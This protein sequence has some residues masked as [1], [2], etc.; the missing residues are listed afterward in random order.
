MASK[1]KKRKNRRPQI[2][3]FKSLYEHLQWAIEVEHFTIPPYLCALWSIKEGTN[4]EAIE[5]IQSVVMEEM[6]HMTLVAN[7]MNAVGIHPEI[8][9]PGFIP[10]YPCR[11]PHSGDHFKVSLERFSKKAIHTFMDIE[12]PKKSG[13]P[14]RAHHYHT[15]AQLYDAVAEGL[16]YLVCEHGEKKVFKGKSHCQVT[17]QHYY[18][19]GGFVFTIDS[20]E[21]AQFAVR[22]I[23]EQGEGKV[24]DKIGTGS[25]FDGD[26]HFGQPPE[27]AH[28]FRFNEIL[29]GQKYVREDTPISGPSGA[30]FDVQWREVHQM[31]KN[32]KVK[33]AKSIPIRNKMNAFNEKYTEL[34]RRLE[35]AFSGEPH[36]IQKAVGQMFQLKYQGIELMRI[37]I[38]EGSKTMVGPSF[39]FYSPA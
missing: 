20:L 15:I 35:R 32:P 4:P 19:G 8:D 39:E 38:K 6:L 17:P 1:T 7:L 36:L 11:M 26:E 30:L 12:E 5:A 9:R 33:F 34:L 21:K 28:Y 3:T 24:P 37:P 16:E 29:L 14:A 31:Q 22:E 23:S 18:G 25:V 13:S 27:P 10:K 2:H